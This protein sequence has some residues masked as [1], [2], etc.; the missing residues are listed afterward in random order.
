MQQWPPRVLEKR[1]R[2]LLS[3]SMPKLPA[4][5]GVGKA[6]PPHRHRR[7]RRTNNNT[8]RQFG[9]TSGFS[10]FPSP[11]PSLGRAAS[12]GTRR[13]RHETAP[14]L[15]HRGKQGYQRIMSPQT[16][17]SFELPG[18]SKSLPTLPICGL[19]RTRLG[20]HKC[21]VC[22][23]RFR[24]AGT[25][26]VHKRAL[27]PWTVHEDGTMMEGAGILPFQCK[28]CK[29]RFAKREQYYAHKKLHTGAQVLSCE[30]CGKRMLVRRTGSKHARAHVSAYPPFDCVC[31][32]RFKDDVAL[33]EH[34]KHREV[35]RPFVCVCGHT[36]RQQV[37]VKIRE[38]V[39]ESSLMNMNEVGRRWT[40]ISFS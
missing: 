21:P 20:R 5:G 27:H 31:G 35:H 38:D 9:S 14:A 25:L 32:K 29:K 36:F 10:L 16:S 4:L 18:G 34:L 3:Q 33:G 1:G 37:T 23:Q 24:R 17:M 2:K 30:K 13:A 22:M 12:I 11:S 40:R 39:R 7:Q 8:G 19:D 28:E 26:D 6:P 15:P